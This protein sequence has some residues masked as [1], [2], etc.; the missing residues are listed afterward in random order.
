MYS[1]LSLILGLLAWGLNLVALL[2]GKRGQG[3]VCSRNVG[4]GVP[5]AP[6]GF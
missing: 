4:G 1:I 6:K 2:R 3:I 5:D